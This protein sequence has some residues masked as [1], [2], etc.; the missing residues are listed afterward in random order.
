MKMPDVSANKHHEVAYSK[1]DMG[2]QQLMDNVRE[3]SKARKA[4]KEMEE[5]QKEKL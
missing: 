1:W 2:A 5:K 4:E 3:M